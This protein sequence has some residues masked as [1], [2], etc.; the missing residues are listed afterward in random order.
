MKKIALLIAV[1]LTCGV[2][3]S[4]PRTVKVYHK[5][6]EDEQLILRVA[7]PRG[8]GPD[9]YECTHEDEV[10]DRYFKEATGAAWDRT[11]MAGRIVRKQICQ[12][13]R[14]WNRQHGVSI[15]PEGCE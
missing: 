12:H 10:R 4:A 3:Y 6:T 5:C 11:W 9:I 7:R 1:L 14:W 2:A 15:M 13:R 8:E